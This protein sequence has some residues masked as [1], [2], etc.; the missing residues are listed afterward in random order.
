MSALSEKSLSLDDVPRKAL[1]SSELANYFRCYI[2]N[3]APWYD[4]SDL[5]CSFSVEVPMLALD[6][7]LLFYAVIALSAMHVSQTTAS[8]ARTIAETYHTQ[9][10]GCLIDLDPEDMLIKKGVA[11]ATTCLL[12]SYEILAGELDDYTP[13]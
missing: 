10:I 1:E 7:P 12:R 3:V 6:E 9:C 13:K 5:Q 11:L 8:S 4:L 2:N